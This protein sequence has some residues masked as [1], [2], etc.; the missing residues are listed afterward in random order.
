M[1]IV[2]DGPAGS[3]KSSTAR[4]VA[5]RIGFTFLDSGAFYRALTLL[6]LQNKS[7]QGL[8]FDDM[9]SCSLHVAYENGNF[10]VLLNEVDVSSEIRNKI[11]SE[12]V[13]TVA[14]M[15]QVRSFV[16]EHLREFVK[17]GHYIADGRD[18]GT[19]VFPDAD[20]KFYFDAGLKERAQRRHKEML[21]SGHHTDLSSVE[22]N[23]RERDSIDSNRKIAPLCKAEDA[24]S[25]DTG[26][27]TLE[28]QIQF[29]INTVKS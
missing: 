6:Y 16:N 8:F 15:P 19:A 2:I 21:A 1:I 23:L 9:K 7:N 13:S 25:V 11:V 12:N 22:E 17:T 18:L 3:G 14:A 24:I 5:E 27:M 28:E 20:Y 4:A 26:K 10:H 29:V